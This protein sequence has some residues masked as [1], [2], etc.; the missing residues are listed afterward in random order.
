MKNK[1]VARELSPATFVLQQSASRFPFMG[2]FIPSTFIAMR[3]SKNKVPR[4]VRTALTSNRDNMINVVFSQPF[5]AP[6]TFTFLTLVLVSNIL[7]SVV[8]A[9]TF[10]SRLSHILIS[11]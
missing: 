2:E 9:D 7:C 3:A 11:A 5:L 10:Y 6:V 1:K 8:A 4:I